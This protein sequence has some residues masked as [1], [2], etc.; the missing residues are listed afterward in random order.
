MMQRQ[1]TISKDGD[2]KINYSGV[3]FRTYNELD[4]FE[5]QRI[6]DCIRKKDDIGTIDKEFILGIFEGHT[7]FSIYFD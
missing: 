6:N 7:M 1:V 5:M 2:F 4:L 3:L